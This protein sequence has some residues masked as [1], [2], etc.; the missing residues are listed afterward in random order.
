MEK[1]FRGLRERDFLR[2]A[3]G[4]G[5]PRTFRQTSG[6]ACR[7]AFRGYVTLLTFCRCCLFDPQMVM[8]INFNGFAF[9]LACL[10]FNLTFHCRSFPSGEFFYLQD[11]AAKKYFAYEAHQVI[12]YGYLSCCCLEAAKLTTMLT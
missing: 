8:I 3:A 9:I 1:D 7:D 12:D 10:Q 4:R 11:A 6:S 5:D 2:T